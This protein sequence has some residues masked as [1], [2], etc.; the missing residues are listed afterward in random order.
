MQSQEEKCVIWEWQG[1]KSN[2]GGS[3]QMGGQGVELSHITDGLILRTDV[4]KLW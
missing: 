1:E 3:K 4:G 2:L